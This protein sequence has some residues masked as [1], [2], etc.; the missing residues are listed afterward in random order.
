MASPRCCA[1]RWAHRRGRRRA[2]AG[3]RALARDGTRLGV[4]LVAE[5]PHRHREVGRRAA[6]LGSDHRQRSGKAPTA[7]SKP[8][9][10]LDQAVVVR[11]RAAAACRRQARSSSSK[12]SSSVSAFQPRFHRVPLESAQP[13]CRRAPRRPIPCVAWTM[14][15]RMNDSASWRIS[16]LSAAWISALIGGR[17]PARRKERVHA[18]GQAH[19]RRRGGRRR[20]AT[21]TRVSPEIRGEDELLPPELVEHPQ[22]PAHDRFA[23]D[24]AGLG[25]NPW[26]VKARHIRPLLERRLDRPGE[27]GELGY[28][29]DAGTCHWPSSR[30][31]PTG[32]LPMI[33]WTV[34]GDWTGFVSR[35]AVRKKRPASRRRGA[36]CYREERYSS[37]Y[38][39][40]CGR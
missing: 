13:S 21:R 34:S 23:A 1:R 6:G 32:D 5:G 29:Q 17:A 18:R 22:P 20:F 10:V 24:R 8:S 39:W 12:S 16:W 4:G 28:Q 25:A 36:G 27:L 37:L 14:P 30:L 31:A 19:G 35:A 9:A 7:S 33:E 38:M 40:I 15:W 3:R 2:G 11:G 26:R